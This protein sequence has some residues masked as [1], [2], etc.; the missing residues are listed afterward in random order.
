MENH[1]I[2]TLILG[3]FLCSYA[4]FVIFPRRRTLVA[5]ISSIVVLLSGVIPVGEI[6]S[7]VNWNVIGIFIGTLLVADV[8]MESRVPAYI[9]EMLINNSKNATFAILS[10]CIM[11]GLISA[12]VENVATVLIIAPIVFH[13][14][15]KLE[16]SPTKIMISVAIS[17]NL[18]GAAT[19][20]GDPPS[21]LLAGF[22]KMNFLDF[23]I[24]KNKPGI[25]FAVEFGAIFS[26]VV[27]YF[28]F[29][30]LKNKVR[31]EVEEK[32]EYWEPT[33]ILI[34]MIV[35]LGVS[36]FIDKSFSH[37]AGII[38]ILFG[39][40]SVIWGKV[41]FKNSA[42]RRIK[43]LDWDTVIFLV[44]IFFLVGSLT[45]SGWLDKIVLLV[46]NTVGKNVL[47]GYTLFVFIAVVCSGFVDNVPFLAMMLPVATGVA[48][49][50]NVSPD[51]FL[52]GL[53]IGASL[54]GNITPIGASANIVACGILK[55]EGYPVNF[56]E[57]VKI[58]LPFTMVAIISSYFFLWF[59]WG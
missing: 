39:I 26:V 51:L 13:L 49:K 14:A 57:F 4:L 12:F 53:L 20:V 3:V 33:I 22:A 21:M 23:F 10:V 9:A 37:M 7:V 44:A 8:F 48:G 30:N 24:Y 55:R 52:F 2:K 25:F 34:L 18:Q 38:C 50:L 54:G 17:S 31:I 36:S 16:I 35:S 28:V 15:K 19:L 46:S 56:F 45:Y 43:N 1:F 29:K 11:S 32:V 58:G 59:V 40:V 6:F 27:L 41:F 47:I 42:F 5:V